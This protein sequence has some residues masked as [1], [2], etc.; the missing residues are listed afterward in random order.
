VINAGNF[1]YA[2]SPITLLTF[3]PVLLTLLPLYLRNL[4]VCAGTLG[5][6]SGVLK[7]A[8]CNSPL[9]DLTQPVK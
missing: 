1:D 4:P 6:D 7:R 3:L 2:N 8:G 9:E 5:I